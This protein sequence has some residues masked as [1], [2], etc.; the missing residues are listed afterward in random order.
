MSYNKEKQC[1]E[2]FIYCITNKLNNKQYWVFESCKK[3]DE[4]LTE[5]R[6]CKK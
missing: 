5:W 6:L 2:G 1:W 4:L 3:I